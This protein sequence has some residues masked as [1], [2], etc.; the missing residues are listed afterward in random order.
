MDQC[1]QNI[2]ALDV[3]NKFNFLIMY[4]LYRRKKE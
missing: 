3:L 2:A 1:K 4:M